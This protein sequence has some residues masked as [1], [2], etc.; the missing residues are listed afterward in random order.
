MVFAAHGGVNIVAINDVNFIGMHSTMLV[1]NTE[2]RK[3]RPYRESVLDT[4]R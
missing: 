4:W 3:E 2:V 1:I